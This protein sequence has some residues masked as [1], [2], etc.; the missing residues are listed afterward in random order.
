M[1]GFGSEIAE[2]DYLYL[3]QMQKLKEKKEMIEKLPETKE[4]IMGSGGCRHHEVLEAY[5][6]LKK[7][8][9]IM[10]KE[11]EKLDKWVGEFE[12]SNGGES[13]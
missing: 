11:I 3:D 6:L 10:N 13:A 8:A 4:P 7:K 1:R 12:P 9:L 2:D 5:H